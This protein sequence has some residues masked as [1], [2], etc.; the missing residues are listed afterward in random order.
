MKYVFERTTSRNQNKL[1]TSRRRVLAMPFVLSF[2][3]SMSAKAATAY[4]LAVA[5]YGNSATAWPYAVA[6]QGGYFEREGLNLTGIRGSAGGTGDVRALLAGDLPYVTSSLLSVLSAVQEGADLKI[7]AEDNKTSATFSWVVMQN[8]PIN[9][10]KDMRGKRI[11]FTSPKST[12]EILNIMLLKTAGITTN[13]VKLIAAGGYGTALTLLEHDAVDVVAVSEPA[14]TANKEKFKYKVVATATQLPPMDSD[15]AITSGK[16]A[17]DS[18]DLLRSILLAH[19]KAVIFMKTNRKESAAYIGKIYQLDV[20]MT[21]SIL[22]QIIDHDDTQGIP[23]FSEGD[24]SPVG[25]DNL[26]NGLKLVGAI[27][28]GDFS[29]WR[30]IVD[31]SFLPDDLKRNLG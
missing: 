19:R 25:M 5:N 8:S 1:L 10:V 2:M 28:E 27:E 22:N 23:F 29:D 20:G 9:S 21:E 24:I 6:F 18:P 15:I 12:S 26:V 7:I 30:S 16:T 14:Y 11:A 4:E 3:G 17:R 31:Q 13:E